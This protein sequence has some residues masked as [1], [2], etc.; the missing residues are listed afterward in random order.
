[1]TPRQLELVQW[2]RTRATVIELRDAALA[3]AKSECSNLEK[4]DLPKSESATVAHVDLPTPRPRPV[5]VLP[6]E[7][8]R[9]RR[10]L[11]GMIVHRR[12]D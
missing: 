10:L 11:M 12:A 8:T 4:S 2:I 3:G 5:L 1:M 9:L 7:H 6:P